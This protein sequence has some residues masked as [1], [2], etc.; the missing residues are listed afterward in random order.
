[1]ITTETILPSAKL[2]IKFSSKRMEVDS[3]PKREFGREVSHT[4]ERRRFNSNGKLSGLNSNKR[5]PADSIEDQKVKRQRVDRK[6]SMQCATILKSLMSH[7]YSWVFS[8]PVDPVALN[9]PD[10]FTIISHPMDFGTIKTKL[11]RNIYLGTE[12]FADDVRLTFSNA[13]K[14]N[15][16]S[17]DVHLMAKEL[18]KIFDRKWKDLVRKLNCEDEHSKSEAETI[19]ETSGRS[20]HTMHSRHKESWPNKTRVSE[21]KGIP[22]S[23]SLA[24]KDARVR[25]IF[26]DTIYFL[27]L[28]K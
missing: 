20:L 11:E 2:K 25:V 15:P 21:K 28:M 12:E 24:S 5:G 19:K 3:G 10:Y 17:N 1:M 16:P 13:M 4:D 7:P 8:K 9:I 18:C 22:K 6:G 14:Y 23:I 26:N 27:V